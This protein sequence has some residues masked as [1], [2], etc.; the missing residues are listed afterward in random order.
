MRGMRV[1]GRHILRRVIVHGIAGI[2]I[3]TIVAQVAGLMAT[4]EVSPATMRTDEAPETC[5]LSNAHSV[6]WRETSGPG[7]RQLWWVAVAPG[8]AAD[9]FSVGPRSVVIGRGVAEK[10]PP[11]WSRI[12]DVG[13]VLETLDPSVDRYATVYR[14][15]YAVGW[16]VVSFRFERVPAVATTYPLPYGVPKGAARE[17]RV[18]PGSV[19]ARNSIE[20]RFVTL[21]PIWSGLLISSTFWG[22]ASLFVSNLIK[23]S[24]ARMR[25][26]RGLCPA[27]GYDRGG[28]ANGSVCPECGHGATAHGGGAA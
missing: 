16:P 12:R 4:T 28:L 17:F 20:P 23:R 7:R 21:N 24:I 5:T 25:G 19:F 3:A 10:R 11:W 8:V 22:L 9:A 27:C 2:V 1:S 13:G 6:N 18:S 26:V 14:Y 15:D